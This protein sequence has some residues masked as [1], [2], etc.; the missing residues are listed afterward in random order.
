MSPQ[1]QADVFA[2][3]LKEGV[4]FL[5][6]SCPFRFSLELACASFTGLPCQCAV[7]S[8]ASPLHSLQAAVPRI[9]YSSFESQWDKLLRGVNNLWC[10]HKI[11]EI[12]QRQAG[13]L[14]S[15]SQNNFHVPTHSEK[16][17]FRGPRSVPFTCFDRPFSTVCGHTMRPVTFTPCQKRWSKSPFVHF[18]QAASN[19]PIGRYK[20]CKVTGVLLWSTHALFSPRSEWHSQDRALEL[21]GLVV[22]EWPMERANTRWWPMQEQMHT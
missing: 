9:T 21:G 12:Q 1:H 11:V 5:F 17:S 7:G 22:S 14:S 4:L 3:F 15:G 16:S 6:Y 18:T 8:A 19:W 2:H 13:P 20:G 10:Q